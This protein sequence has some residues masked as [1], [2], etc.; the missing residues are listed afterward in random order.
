[1]DTDMPPQS[2]HQAGW[3]LQF[4]HHPMLPPM[5]HQPMHQPGQELTHTTTHGTTSDIQDMD[6]GDYKHEEYL[7]NKIILFK[8]QKKI[9]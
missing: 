5:L 7:L 1:M 8:V 6:G 9:S 3:D 4:S 2:Y